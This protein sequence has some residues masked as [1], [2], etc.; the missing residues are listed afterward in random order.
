MSTTINAKHKLLEIADM[1]N[2]AK[3]LNRALFMAC[4]DVK[5]R[6][7]VNAL[8]ALSEEID[9]RIEIIRD[10]VDEVREELA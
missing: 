9:E 5:D 3:D 1:I 2:T 8:Q 4:G 7:A 6:Y 10:R